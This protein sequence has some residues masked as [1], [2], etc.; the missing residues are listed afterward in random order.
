MA[1]LK[2]ELEVT[3]PCCH[4]T[5][6]VDTNLGRIVSHKEPERG[7]KPELTEAQIDAIA[8]RVVQKLSD[9]VVREIAWDVVPDLAERAVKRRIEE[10]ERG[11]E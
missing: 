1:R 4:S 10:L 3:C 6:V 2:S 8:A 11:P 7:D 5:L 9:R